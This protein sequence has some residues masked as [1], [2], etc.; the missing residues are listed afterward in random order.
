MRTKNPG[1][2]NILQKQKTVSK[3][4]QNRKSIPI[5]RPEK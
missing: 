3:V 5:R 4:S 2:P 1:F